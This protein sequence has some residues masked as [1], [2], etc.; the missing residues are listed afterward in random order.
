M[1]SIAC[2][3]AVDSNLAVHTLKS[4]DSSPKN[5]VMFV[6]RVLVKCLYLVSVG[7]CVAKINNFVLE[8]FARIISLILHDQLN[9]D[10]KS[11]GGTLFQLILSTLSCMKKNC[12]GSTFRD[13]QASLMS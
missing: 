12:R 9:I 1:I 10:L 2:R 6:C 13:S 5:M 7:L 8:V 4:T 11:L 3:M